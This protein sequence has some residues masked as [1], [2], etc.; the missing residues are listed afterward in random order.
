MLLC[1]MFCDF[2]CCFEYENVLLDPD[3][4]ADDV[5]VMQCQCSLSRRRQTPRVPALAKLSGPARIPQQCVS[6]F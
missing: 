3:E 5:D 2:V 4:D 1:V 6:L